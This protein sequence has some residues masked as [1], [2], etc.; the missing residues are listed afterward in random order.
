MQVKKNAPLSTLV[1]MKTLNIMK[2]KMKVICILI[3]AFLTIHSYSQKEE[4]NIIIKNPVTNVKNQ[5]ESGQYCWSYATCSFLESELIR[6]GKGAYDLSEDFFIYHAYIDKAQNYVLRKG[7]ARFYKGGLAHDV[8]K[9]I[10]E[11]GVIPDPFYKIDY[12]RNTNE[13]EDVLSSYLITILKEEYLTENW[14][15]HYLALLNSYY[16]NLSNQFEFNDSTFT[17]KTFVDYIGINYDDYVSITSVTHHPFNNE[18]IL[19][20]PDNYV[21]GSYFNVP[22]NEFTQIVDTCLMKGY[23]L[24]WDGCIEGRG[25]SYDDGLAMEPVYNNYKELDL[26]PHITE[27]YIDQ[28]KRQIAFE[29]LQTTDDHL[30]HIVGIAE[31]KQGKKFYI[32]KDS[33]GEYG[34]YKGF[35]Y[36]SEAFLKMKTI[37]ITLNKN[38]LPEAIRRKINE[39]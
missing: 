27:H 6:L 19:E 28:Q 36:M 21:N 29:R 23:T 5:M 15:K 8:L 14:M 33:G 37:S 7:Y 4:F 3:L 30:M 31:N 34:P 35:L 38:S 32:V 9:I 25:F 26:K 10:K 17:P 1:K 13:P 2:I 16:S 18:F 20:I 39:K 12:I 22:L 24:V 11:K